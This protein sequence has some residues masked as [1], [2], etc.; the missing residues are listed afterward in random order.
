MTYTLITGASSG[1]GR[2]LAYVFAKNS[3]NLIITARNEKELNSLKLELEKE[4]GIQVIIIVADLS[5]P[6]ACGNLYEK[7]QQEGYIID[8]L[9][10]NAGFGD[11]S[12]FVECDSEKYKNL[13]QVN[14]ASLCELTRLYGKEMKQQERGRILNIASIAAFCPGPYMA[15]YYASKSFVLSFSQAVYEELK[16]YGVSVTALCLGPT[17]T[18]FEQTA[19]LEK[20]NMFKFFKP[21]SPKDVALYAY[22]CMIKGKCTAYFSL[23]AKALN[24]ISR[25]MPNFIARKFSKMINT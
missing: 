7:T 12:E 13:I 14:I 18:H 19:N 16:P 20:A 3:N 21:K 2:E 23:Q 10:N 15:C 24:I 11:C 1:I 5:R 17:S 6:D 8:N 9:I 4:Y 25:L 22:K